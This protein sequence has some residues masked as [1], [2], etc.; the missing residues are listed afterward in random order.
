MDIYRE[1]CSHGLKSVIRSG[2]P[3]LIYEP[4]Y[5]DDHA[6]DA[7]ILAHAAAEKC[8][9]NAPDF[10]W[11]SLENNLK[12]VGQRQERS[13]PKPAFGGMGQSSYL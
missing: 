8:R 13:K 2:T 7:M 3:V 1:I 11:D 10:D 12:P 5:K 4:T 9:Y 6:L